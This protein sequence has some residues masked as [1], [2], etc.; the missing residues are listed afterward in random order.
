LVISHVQDI[1]DQWPVGAQKDRLANASQTLRIPYWDWA[2]PA[3]DGQH[4]MPDS[5]ATPQISVI[6]PNGSQTIDNPLYTYKF[7]PIQAGALNSPVNA[8]FWDH[9]FHTNKLSS[10]KRTVTLPHMRKQLLMTTL[11]FSPTSIVTK[12]S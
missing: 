9:G 2:K 6:T 3:P 5:M 4:T 10:L 12:H 11:G 8:A 1:V 7:H